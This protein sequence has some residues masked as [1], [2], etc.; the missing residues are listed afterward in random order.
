MDKSIRGFIYFSLGSNFKSVNLGS[1]IINAFIQ[2]FSELPYQI[3]W[4]FESDSI[5]KKPDNVYINTWLPQQ[6]ILGKYK[7][8]KIKYYNEIK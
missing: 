5:A 6:G 8:K 7:K 4:K 2:A 1:N 3:I